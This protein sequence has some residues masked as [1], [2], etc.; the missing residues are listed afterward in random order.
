MSTTNYPRAYLVD[1]RPA[2]TQYRAR[3]ARPTGLIVVHTAESHPDEQG[4][5]TGAENVAR[6][7][8]ERTTYGSYHD[9]ADSDSDVHVVPYPMAAFGD[10]TGSNEFAIHLSLATEAHRWRTLPQEWKDAAVDN[11]AGC[12]AR[13]AK[14]LKANGYPVPPARRVT[15]AQSE[16]GMAGFISHA[17]RD[18]ARRSDPGKEFPW[19][20]FLTAYDRLMSEED[21]MP[22][23]S[24]WSDKDRKAL[25]GDVADAVVDKIV[26]RAKDVSKAVL[27]G[28]DDIV[29][30]YPGRGETGEKMAL[31]RFVHQIHG[32]VRASYER[33]RGI[34]PKG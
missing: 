25:A 11:L 26:A 5:D 29:V 23:Y 2:K 7:I 20:R 18:P 14:W 4:P 9:L 15:R 21:D 6:F 19:D 28:F 12:A 1:H 3:R 33:E 24:D 16:R 22:R 32:Y 10:G 30:W 34:G 27:K 13:A 8:A 17:E 31:P